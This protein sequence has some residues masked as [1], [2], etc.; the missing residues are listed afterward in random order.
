MDADRPLARNHIKGKGLMIDGCDPPLSDHKLDSAHFQ[1]RAM[2]LGG[3]DVI[4]N[5]GGGPLWGC[6]INVEVLETIGPRS[7]DSVK[8]GLSWG[9]NGTQATISYV[10]EDLSNSNSSF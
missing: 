7:S 5:K 6:T 9:S 10:L 3:M 8:D 1:S 2:S 4:G